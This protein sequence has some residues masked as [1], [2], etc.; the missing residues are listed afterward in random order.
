M[1]EDEEDEKPDIKKLRDELRSMREELRK[2]IREEIRRQSGEQAA[3]K[4]T[5]GGAEAEAEVELE[6]EECCPAPGLVFSKSEDG[7]KVIIDVGSMGEMVEEMVNGIKGEIQKS[8]LVGRNKI[9]IT[10]GGR[11]QK[12][13]ID[14]EASSKVFAALGNEHRMRILKE[15]ATGGMYANELEEKIP[16]SASTLSSH[17][18]TLEDAGLV[19]QEAVRG[20][21]LITLQGRRALRAARGFSGGD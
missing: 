2:E 18:K 11:R 1:S 16:I 8:I 9:M 13:E 15:L 7:K 17:L 21:Y 3:E 14:E 12:D 19:M 4:E 5:K 10:H 20:R 6:A